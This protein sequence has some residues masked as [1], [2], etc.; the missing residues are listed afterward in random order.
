MSDENLKAKEL[1][2]AGVRVQPR[3]AH[4]VI[5]DENL[6]AKELYITGTKEDP[7]YGYQDVSSK[8]SESRAKRVCHGCFVTAGTKEDPLYRCQDASSRAS[9]ISRLF[10]DTV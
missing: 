9:S 10:R 4:G 8:A 1:C 5:I 7:L 2:T 3:V 6:K